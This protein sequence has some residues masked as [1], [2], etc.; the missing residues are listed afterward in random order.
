VSKKRKETIQVTG[1][2]HSSSYIKDGADLRNS[3]RVRKE[4]LS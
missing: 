2:M 4:N 1:T 3:Q